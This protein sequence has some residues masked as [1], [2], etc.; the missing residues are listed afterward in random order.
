MQRIDRVEVAVS[1]NSMTTTHAHEVLR[2][3]VRLSASGRSH[4]C[5]RAHFATC[6]RFCMICSCS[7]TG[8]DHPAAYFFFF[9][10]DAEWPLVTGCDVAAEGEGTSSLTSSA[11]PG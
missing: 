9:C 8:G 2:L 1:V 10:F 7:N 4:S 5:A 11:S 3:V 6:L